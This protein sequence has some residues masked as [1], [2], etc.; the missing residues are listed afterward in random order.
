MFPFN[1]LFEVSWWFQVIW[2]GNIGL[3][4]DNYL[5]FLVNVISI[6]NAVR[7]ILVNAELWDEHVRKSFV[8]YATQL[9]S[10]VLL[11]MQKYFEIV[12]K[13]LKSPAAKK[14][15]NNLDWSMHASFPPEVSLGKG[16]LKICSKFIFWYFHFDIYLKKL[17][18]CYQPISCH[19]SFSILPENIRKSEFFLCSQ[20]VQ[21][22]TS[23]I[24][25][26]KWNISLLSCLSQ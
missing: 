6:F 17:H 22:V 21:K 19:W 4:L 24:K 20:G 5:H 11:K 12:L 7:I 16:D 9:A 23:D 13:L 25:R 15:A 2:K 18:T 10:G 14:A 8:I 26:V 1:I 3:N